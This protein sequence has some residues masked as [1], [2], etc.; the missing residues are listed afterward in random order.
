MF[1]ASDQA[2]RP[3]LTLIYGTRRPPAGA[4]VNADR[5]L[6]EMTISGEARLDRSDG[7]DGASSRSLLEM[8]PCE[9]ELR[10]VT[11]TGEIGS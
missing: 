10:G 6:P 7:G 11:G 9:V 8:A 4:D 2:Q 1:D 5:S 3:R